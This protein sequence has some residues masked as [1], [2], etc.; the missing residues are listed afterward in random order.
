MR[1]FSFRLKTILGVALV[2]AV[3]LALLIVSVLDFL[4]ESHES[5]LRRYSR[6][7]ANSFAAMTT[8]AVLALDL[9]RLQAY[10]RDLVDNPD[11]AYARIRNSDGV[12]LAEAGDATFLQHPFR[13]DMD[14][15]DVDDGVFDATAPIRVDKQD[16]G[17]VEV[18]IEVDDIQTIY[19]RTRFWSL[20]I[21]GGEMALVALF[22]LM[23]GTYLTRQLAHLKA[24]AERL[25]AGDL[26]YQ[27]PVR[28]R[29]EL[30]A[31][32]TAFNAMSES[33]RTRSEQL[34]GVFALSPDGFLS[35][36]SQGVARLANPALCRMLGVEEGQ[37]LGA[38]RQQVEGLLRDL[39]SADR[40][41][42]S[43]DDIRER[44]QVAPDTAPERVIFEVKGPPRRSLQVTARSGELTEVALLLHF[45]D[46]SRDLE[47][48]QMKSEFLSAAAHELR[49]PMASIYGFTELLLDRD[50]DEE[51]RRGMLGVVHEQ[52]SLLSRII[53]ELLDLARI[54]ARA[55]KDFDRRPLD[56]PDFVVATLDNYAPA[57]R[58]RFTI[59]RDSAQSL[60]DRRVHADPDKLSQALVNI[61]SNAC[62]Y[63]SPGSAVHLSF[64]ADGSERHPM[65]GVQVADRGVGMNPEQLARVFERFWRADASGKTPGTGLGMSLVKEIIE[66][67]DGRVEM[68]SEPGVGTR[69]TLWLPMLDARA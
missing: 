59:D 67:H 48:E 32:A 41:F 58:P 26:G 18:G 1:S 57:E 61:L 7:T 2:E 54:E 8:D 16:Y 13:A 60:P 25:A 66:L 39:S 37:L 24:G 12:V 51:T 22:S 63:S 15:H 34:A 68:H 65:L 14:L 19:A 40:P 38:S 49:T 35:L 10:A 43:L 23:L 9:G 44:T 46:I 3:L 33:L 4:H 55:G 31:T 50:F 27:V 42:T 56:L 20:S 36:D 11:I 21:A 69:V 5:Q 62:K 53:N 29:D 28:G 47:V 64:L 6:A 45:R 30:A 17:W 52:S